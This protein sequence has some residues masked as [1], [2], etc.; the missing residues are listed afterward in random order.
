MPKFCTGTGP[1]LLEPVL[2]GSEGGNGGGGGGIWPYTVMLNHCLRM[3]YSCMSRS[4]LMGISRKPFSSM[5]QSG[6]F[7]RFTCVADV[8]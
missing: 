2:A 7:K 3:L 5:Y 4:S 6:L 1:E 8:S